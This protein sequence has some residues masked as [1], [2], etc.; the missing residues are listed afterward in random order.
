MPNECPVHNGPRAHTRWHTPTMRDSE[1]P[2]WQD[3]SV[4]GR[5]LAR[6]RRLADLSQRDLA[7]RLGVSP[8][9]VGQA[10]AGRRRV[11]IP[12]LARAL[13]QADLRLLV[14]DAAGSAVHPIPDETVRDRAGR[15][16]PSHHD[17]APG[18][19]VAPARYR[20][21]TLAVDLSAVPAGVRGA[22]RDQRRLRRSGGSSR[23]V[24]DHPSAEALEERRR[25]KRRFPSV[26]VTRPPTEEVPIACHCE[27]AC[28]ETVCVPSCGCRCEAR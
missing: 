25:L 18:D 23:P 6:A 5:F 10:E 17:V 11:S 21:G 2:D 20:D 24:D 7:A 28:F 8:A 22:R 14:L 12:L 4:P 1:V 16:F 9:M 27:D 3:A 15:R 13:E 26:R 19:E